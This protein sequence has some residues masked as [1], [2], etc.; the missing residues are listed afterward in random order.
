M[1]CTLEMSLSE[2][3]PPCML[4]CGTLLLDTRKNS[5]IHYYKGYLDVFKHRD[6]LSP[7]ENINLLHSIIF[8]AT[9]VCH[10]CQ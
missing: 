1:A 8:C 5:R 6:A 3:E 9:L 10:H 4:V 7:G 2:I